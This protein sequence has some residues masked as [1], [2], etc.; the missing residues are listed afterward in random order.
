VTLIDAGPLVAAGD[1]SDYRRAEC[2]RALAETRPPRYVPAT[3][4]AEVC[5]LLEDRAGSEAEACFLDMFASGYLRP[6]ELTAADYLRTAEL[7]R[8][9]AD[10]PL[11]GVDASLVAL[12][13]RL[14]I[15]ELVTIDLRHFSIVRP[16][17]VGQGPG[18]S[19]HSQTSAR[20]RSR[21]PARRSRVDSVGLP[22]PRSIRWG[23]RHHARRD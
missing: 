6:V 11:G 1:G 16:R 17:H 23:C 10:L 7:V 4:V 3:I 19:C 13:E 20:W 18:R 12:A 5:H 14:G 2:V 15:T 9:Y 21:A 8:Q 22:A